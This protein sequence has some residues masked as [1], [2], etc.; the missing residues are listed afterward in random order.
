[1]SPVEPIQHTMAAHFHVRSTYPT[2]SVHATHR[3][4]TASAMDPPPQTFQST[5]SLTDTNKHP[6]YFYQT[7]PLSQ[8]HHQPT[9]FHA[10]PCL[11]GN[12]H[13]DLDNDPQTPDLFN[14]GATISRSHCLDLTHF[15]LPTSIY[16]LIYPKPIFPPHPTPTL[17]LI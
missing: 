10:R 12:T 7:K 3:T 13:D 15:N 6:R 1:M 11:R 16:V 2:A 9:P 17:P 5:T 8:T 14:A 4:P